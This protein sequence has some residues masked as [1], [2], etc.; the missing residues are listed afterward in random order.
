[1]L[2][3]AIVRT[4]EGCGVERSRWGLVVAAGL[5]VFVAQLDATIVNIA[6]KTMSDQTLQSLRRLLHQ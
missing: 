6:F 1:M 5:S 4:A 3:P 2:I